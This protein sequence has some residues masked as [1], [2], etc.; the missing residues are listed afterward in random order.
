MAK[1]W[2]ELILVA[3]I[4]AL[5]GAWIYVERETS[6]I[7]YPSQDGGTLLTKAL[8]RAAITGE[9]QT[10]SGAEF[11]EGTWRGTELTM[12]FQNADYREL[13]VFPV[14]ARNVTVSFSCPTDAAIECSEDWGG[15]RV[16]FNEKA[17]WDFSVSCAG[18][19]CGVSFARAPA[20]RFNNLTVTPLTDAESLR[21]LANNVA[22]KSA[23]A[24]AYIDHLKTSD[25]ITKALWVW[26][27]N[28]NEKMTILYYNVSM[29]YSVLEAGNYE[30][31]DTIMNS[32]YGDY[33][34]DGTTELKE[35]VGFMEGALAGADLT[36]CKGFLNYDLEY[37]RQRSRDEDKAVLLRL[38]MD[39]ADKTGNPKWIIANAARQADRT[40]GTAE[41]RVLFL[42]NTTTELGDLGFKVVAVEDGLCGEILSCGETGITAKRDIGAYVA[43]CKTDGGHNVAVGNLNQRKET[44]EKC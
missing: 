41:T 17:H 13:E 4:V 31:A 43:V 32:R 21:L 12:N 9:T 25:P 26:G 8:E 29:A 37:A 36:A 33:F 28:D 16:R 5:L 6:D 39:C 18:G 42:E 24:D 20:N 11:R 19:R 44:E 1:H 22:E 2:K 14:L 23:E 38:L 30:Y 35:H 3:L 27:K 40:N 7:N 15:S 34:F 10:L